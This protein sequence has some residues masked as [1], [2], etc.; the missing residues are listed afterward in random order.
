MT[1]TTTIKPEPKLDLSRSQ[2]VL[3]PADLAALA[4]QINADHS[5]I[6]SAAKSIVTR[7]ISAGEALIAAKAAVPDGTWLRWLKANCIVSERT[8]QLYMQLAENKLTLEATVRDQSA[9]IAD[10]T[11]NG[12]I[13]MLR[14]TSSNRTAGANLD[15]KRL[16]T[17]LLE[18]V[19]RLPNP[20]AAAHHVMERLQEARLI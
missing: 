17:D 1:D 7:A 14:A 9:T 19:L 13:K 12:A 16:A 4:K 2:E 5:A 8:A 15:V 6:V 10:Q 20:A 3:P 18:K 11:L